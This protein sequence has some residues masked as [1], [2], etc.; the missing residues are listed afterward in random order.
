MWKY[1]GIEG[2]AAEAPSYLGKYHGTLVVLGGGR[3]V[4]DDYNRVREEPHQV[5]AVN[6][7]G[8]YYDGTLEHWV[9]LHANYLL[10]WTQLRRLHGRMGHE[11]LTHTNKPSPGIRVAWEISPYGAYSGLYAAEVGLVLGYDKIILCGVPMDGSGKFCEPP[12]V[13]GEHDD[14]NAKKAWR[15]TVQMNAEFQRV[16][17]VSGWSKELLG[18]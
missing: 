2:G 17:S 3:C 18:E 15:Q 13:G 7:V 9:S 4:W 6:D 5:M 11:C 10:L 12:W 14:K 8:M 1:R 16:K